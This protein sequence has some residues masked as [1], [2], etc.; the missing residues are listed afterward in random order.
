MPKEVQV[1][2]PRNSDCVSLCGKRYLVDVIDLRIL[3]W[4]LAWIILVTTMP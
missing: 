1:L 3:D 2:A 4:R